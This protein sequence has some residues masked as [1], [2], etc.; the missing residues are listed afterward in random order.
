MAQKKSKKAKFI[1]EDPEILK[2]KLVGV[3][4]FLIRNKRIISGIFIGILLVISVVILY[5]RWL[6]GQELEAQSQLSPAVFFFENNEFE[7][8]LNGDDITTDGLLAITE[9]YKQ[10]KAANLAHF[11]T[12]V[13][14]LS[15]PIDSNFANVNDAIKHLKA[16]DSDDLFLKARGLA[17]L[18]DAYSE[19]HDYETA[20]NYYQKAVDYKPNQDL[21][22]LY[23]LKLALAFE[24]NTQIEE[25]KTTYTRLIDKYP[26]SSY[27]NKAKQYSSIL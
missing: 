16:F 11:Y 22:P 2:D 12:G 14:Y 19:L 20:I 10:T 17:L 13:I 3:E 9:D 24:K 25:A 6:K 8:A 1:A 27:S 18:G 26:N 23:L 7:K 15:Q 21:T 4:N 5:N